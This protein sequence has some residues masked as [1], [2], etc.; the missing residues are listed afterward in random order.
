MEMCLS[1]EYSDEYRTWENNTG[2]CVIYRG[3]ASIKARRGEDACTEKRDPALL[4][5]AHR[6]Q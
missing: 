6:V 3:A 4:N 5:I 2:V 1:D